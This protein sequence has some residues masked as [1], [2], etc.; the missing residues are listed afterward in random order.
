MLTQHTLLR[1]RNT[2]M[3]DTHPHAEL[4]KRAS[5]LVTHLS[6]PDPGGHRA[7]VEWPSQ[8][9]PQSWQAF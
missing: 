5:L 4:L 9:W 7:Q 3:P 6:C 8:A 2:E 1:S